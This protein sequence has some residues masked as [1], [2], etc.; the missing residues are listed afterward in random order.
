MIEVECVRPVAWFTTV[1]GTLQASPRATNW[2]S[3]FVQ[4]WHLIA[5]G[6]GQEEWNVG[7]RPRPIVRRM[8]WRNQIVPPPWRRPFHHGHRA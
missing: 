1:I 4:V 6:S 3:V 7:A 2:S 8:D 5:A